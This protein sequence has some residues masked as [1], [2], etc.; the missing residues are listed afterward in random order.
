[1]KRFENDENNQQI[2][3]LILFKINYVY[4]VGRLMY[5]VV[6]ILKKVS[7]NPKVAKL[8]FY[9]Y[10]NAVEVLFKIDDK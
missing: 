10:S 4:L 8:H 9:V 5:N 3:L 1:M 7:S 2:M 6:V